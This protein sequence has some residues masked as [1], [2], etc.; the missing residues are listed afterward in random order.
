MAD[1]DPTVAG[2]LAPETRAAGRASP[3]AT[4]P[5][6]HKAANV[7]GNWAARAAGTGF[8]TSVLLPLTIDPRSWP[9]IWQEL[10][11]MQQAVWQLQSHMQNNWLQGWAAWTNEFTQA[12]GANTAAKLVEQELDLVAQWQQLV[13][14]QTT[15][16]VRLLENLEVNYAYWVNEKLR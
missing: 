4:A 15:D 9:Q 6:M 11:Q 13:N 12:R 5:L 10:W 1:I 16:V 3:P 8:A 14:N 7:M 2:S